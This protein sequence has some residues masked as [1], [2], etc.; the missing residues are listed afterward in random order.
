LTDQSERDFAE[1]FDAFARAVRRARGAPPIDAAKALTLSQFALLEVLSTREQARVADL[2][3]EAGVTPPTV[4]RILDA[5]ERRG[6]IRRERA[7]ADRRAVSV[8]LTDSGRELLHRQ[9]RW[10]NDRRRAFVRSLPDDQQAL[11]APLLY[12]LAGLIDE[13][14]AGPDELTASVD[15]LAAGSETR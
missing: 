7:A 1:A 14:A 2:A 11:L 8:T 5:L 4:T 9:Q 13:L 15:E 12:G 3:A 6:V 10:I